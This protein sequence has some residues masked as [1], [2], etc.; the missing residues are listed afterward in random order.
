MESVFLNPNKEQWTALCKRPAFDYAALEAIVMPVLA[1]V[2]ANGD[3]AVKKYAA[4]FDKVVLTDLRVS[5]AEI[6]EAAALVEE[7]L[8]AAIQL[9]KNNIQLFHES[10]KEGIQ[11]ISTTDG[12][13]C[14]RK[15]VAIQNVG[16]YIPGGT[17]PLFSTLLMLG[18]PAQIAGCSNIIMCTPSNNNGQVSPVILYT[19]QLL[20][21]KNIFKIGGVQAIAA[22]A[23]GTETIPAVSKIFGPGNQY[24]TAAKQLVNREGIAIDMPAGP[25]ELAVYADETAVPAFVAADLL[26]QAEHGPDS[27]VLLVASSKDILHA[28]KTQVELQL[29]DLPRK[30]TASVA[31]KH[32]RWLVMQDVNI[33]FNFLNEYAAEHLIIA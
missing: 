17:A 25:S 10:Q 4:Q 24:V 9:A 22:M 7:N 20:G 13:L 6:N 30:E 14:W 15:S 32:S 2:K 27:Q 18:I 21:I 29:Q 12:V 23:Y 33:A 3:A 11:K 31:L 26:S 28:V 19:A 5:E 8:K 1:D 16:L